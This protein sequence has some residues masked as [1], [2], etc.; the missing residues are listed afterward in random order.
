MRFTF[1]GLRNYLTMRYRLSLLGFPRG[2]TYSTLLARMTRGKT[3]VLTQQTIMLS[4]SGMICVMRWL[5]SLE[6]LAH[7]SR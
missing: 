1:A 3:Y 4:V 6:K 2:F 5:S 7:L